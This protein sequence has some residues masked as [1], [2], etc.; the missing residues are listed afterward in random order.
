MVNHGR[1][2]DLQNDRNSFRKLVVKIYAHFS[3]LNKLVYLGG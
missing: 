3:N 2:I 1:N